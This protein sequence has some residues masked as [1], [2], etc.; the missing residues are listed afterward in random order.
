MNS[1]PHPQLQP[2]ILLAKSFNPNTETWQG[3]YTLV[4]HTAAVVN[5]VTAI[6]NHLGDRLTVYQTETPRQETLY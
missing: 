5:A 1:K 4:G 6:V 2:N 3:A